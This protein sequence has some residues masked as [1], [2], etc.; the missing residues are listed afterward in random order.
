MSWANSVI[1]KMIKNTDAEF[2]FKSLTDYEVVL[3]EV[4]RKRGTRH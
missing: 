4:A 3:S 1:V 2:G